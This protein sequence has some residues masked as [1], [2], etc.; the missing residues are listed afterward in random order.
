MK[1]I[2]GKVY[3]RLIGGRMEEK[4]YQKWIAAHMR[5]LLEGEKDWEAFE[6]KP[7][8]SIVVPLYR[9]PEPF[10]QG[11]GNIEETLVGFTDMIRTGELSGDEAVDLFMDE[12]KGILRP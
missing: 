12:A 8:Y 5:A 6:K 11:A 7:L 4:R 2:A 9:T 1:N 10:L 3:R